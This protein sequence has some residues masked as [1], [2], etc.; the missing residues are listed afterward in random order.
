MH[1]TNMKF[2]VSVSIHIEQTSFTGRSD[3]VPV[4]TTGTIFY[5]KCLFK[6][7]GKEGIYENTGEDFYHIE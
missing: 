6:E 7:M 3:S 4:R 5:S 2:E 1:G